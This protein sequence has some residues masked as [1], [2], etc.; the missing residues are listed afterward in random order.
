IDISRIEDTLSTMAINAGRW[1]ASNVFTI[2]QS[3]VQFFLQLFV[4]LYL[5]FFFIRDGARIVQSISRILPFEYSLQNRLERRFVVVARAVIKGTFLISA[6]QGLT[7]SLVFWWL[8]I[9]APVVWGVVMALMALL[10]VVGPAIVWVPA[11]IFLIA[12]G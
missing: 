9:R 3:T 5:L 1:V 11:A 4:M 10:P 12:T 7:G 8:G 6:L 2:G